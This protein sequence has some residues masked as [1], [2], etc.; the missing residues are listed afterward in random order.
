MA[1]LQNYTAD[2]GKQAEPRNSSSVYNDSE[3]MAA[4]VR[5]LTQEGKQTL[6]VIE[7]HLDTKAISEIQKDTA[8]ARAEL[9]GMY[10]D[11]TKEVPA[12]DPNYIAGFV[13][14]AG[15]RLQKSI[16]GSLDKK[17]RTATA[18]RMI[19]LTTTQVQA[20]FVSRLEQVRAQQIGEIAKA[21]TLE[22]FNVSRNVVYNDYT[23]FGSVLAEQTALLSTNPQL[24]PQ[25]KAA[26]AVELR[27]GLAESA[28]N[29]LGAK[30]PEEAV[31][32]LQNGVWDMWI[33]PE[34]KA[35]FI[36]AFL[37]DISTR[38][39]KARTAGE[40]DRKLAGEEAF[41]QILKA[42]ADDGLTR[43]MIE[44]FY[45]VL[46]PENYKAALSM[47]D[48]AD[49][50]EDDGDALVYLEGLI[51]TDPL[52]AK[53]AIIAARR[54][55]KIRNATLRTYMSATQSRLEGLGHTSELERQRRNLRVL[56]PPPF[57]D[58]SFTS[59]KWQYENALKE[60]NARTSVPGLTD[61]DHRKIGRD[62]LFKY[63]TYNDAKQ[64][65]AASATNEGT[66]LNMIKQRDYLMDQYQDA[67][68]AFV[69][70]RMPY[71]EWE[72]QK[73][74]YENQIN[75]LQQRIDALTRS[76]EE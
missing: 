3:A 73:K 2:I 57:A 75:A 69:T 19:D 71:A 27:T 20:D 52:S 23:Q 36:N 55:G 46:T 35:S 70:G 25:V 44:S 67:A 53:E 49:P 74:A 58:A 18:K 1:Q 72:L 30:S 68:D 34:K 4:A 40:R 10:E 32:Q 48:T 51:D 63:S 12:D 26:L 16:G 64:R 37:S 8:I 61:E 29:G 17:Y 65:N 76:P 14:M 45:G 66:R 22:A 7:Q 47:V 50:E 15:E 21:N 60:F 13:E 62:V 38:A 59:M 54:S 56:E 5:G 24:D 43:E 11:Y 31:Q 39:E 9:Q 6:K 28:V 42:D 33:A 41:K